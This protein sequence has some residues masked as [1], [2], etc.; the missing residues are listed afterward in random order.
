MEVDF[1]KTPDGKYQQRHWPQLMH[2]KITA[3]LLDELQDTYPQFHFEIMTIFEKSSHAG[4]DHSRVDP[5]R[6]RIFTDTDGVVIKIPVN[7]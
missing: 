3:D 2:R 4:G 1:G 7:G 6:V 5:S